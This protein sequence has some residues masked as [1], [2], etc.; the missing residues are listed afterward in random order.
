M[1]TGK[2]LTAL[3]LDAKTLE[4]VQARFAKMLGEPV[5]LLQSIDPSLLGGIRVEIAGRVYDDSIRS[6]L[7]AL[8]DAALPITRR[9]SEAQEAHTRRIVRE[10][11][12]EVTEQP[13]TR[14]FGRVEHVATASPASR[15]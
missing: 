10:Q 7:A 8:K 4:A 2:L 1:L 12:R 11:L 6:Q 5:E 3:P 13:R 15:A 14:G 9:D